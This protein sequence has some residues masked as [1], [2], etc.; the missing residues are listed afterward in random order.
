M[1]GPVIGQPGH[2]SYVPRHRVTHLDG[3]PRHRTR[4]RTI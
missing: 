3:W 4:H 2:R 1:G